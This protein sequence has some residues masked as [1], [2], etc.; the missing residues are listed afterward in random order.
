MAGRVEG[1]KV[2]VTGA[3]QGLGEAIA[4]RLAAEGARVTL[5][6]INLAGAQNVATAINAEHGAKTAKAFALDV[7]D[8]AQWIAALDAANSAMGGLS[9]L[10]NNAGIAKQ[11]DVE[12]F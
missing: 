3:A 11:G 12:A 2:F 5:A 9:A 7:T 10:V 8:E 6:D 4:R 1:K